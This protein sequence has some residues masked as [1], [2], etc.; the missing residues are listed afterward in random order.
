MN[1]KYYKVKNG[2]S[3][4]ILW[5]A[6]CPRCGKDID[7]SWPHFIDDNDDVVCLDC[8]FIAG[9]VTAA[10][11]LHDEYHGMAKRSVV[12]DGKIYVAFDDTKFPFEQTNKDIRKSGR[13]T[14]WRNA[15]FERDNFTCARCGKHGGELNAHHIKPFASHPD[16]RFD[17]KNG[18]TLCKACH[19]EVHR[20]ADHEWL[21]S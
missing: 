9:Q 16:D 10:E 4:V 11:Y 1:K 20:E 7:C 12:H 8:A 13:Y 2:D 14:Q 19:D 6:E 21:Y 3:D 5:H 18:I 17:I 15:V